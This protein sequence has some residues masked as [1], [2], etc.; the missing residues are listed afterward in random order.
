MKI[1]EVI[2]VEGRDDT[3]KIKQAVDADT[4]ETNGSAIDQPTLERI[5]HAQA[6][7]GVIIFTD[8]D[9]PGE[10][11]RRIVQQE[12]PGCKHAFMPK[13]EAKGSNGL[14]V[15]HATKQAIHEALEAVYELRQTSYQPIEWRPYLLEYGLV[16]GAGAKPRRERLGER[17]KIGYANAKQLEKRLNMFQITVDEFESV[18]DEI[19]KEERQQ[20]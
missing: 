12:V 15:E 16:G 17:L 5:K 2:V 19:L 18:M 10:R 8:P 7:R 20:P 13:D 14:G 9:F 6:K 3:A 11:I 4:I 1:Q